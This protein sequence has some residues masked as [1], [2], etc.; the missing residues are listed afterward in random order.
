M[1]V[2]AVEAP[3]SEPMQQTFNEPD[4]LICYYE[5]LKNE[6]LDL[7]DLE[8]QPADGENWKVILTQQ[9]NQYQCSVQKKPNTDFFF[10]IV[11]DFEATMEEAFDLL[12]DI[13]KRKEWDELT[14]SAGLV[15][16]TS[17]VSTIQVSIF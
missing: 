15:E 16:R 9:R 12:A 10:R 13:E 17:F 7:V 3:K 5:E 1:E 6:F 11:V 4:R 2:K 8:K 14:Q